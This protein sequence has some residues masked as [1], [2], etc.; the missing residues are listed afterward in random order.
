MCSEVYMLDEIHRIM[1]IHKL[2]SIWI[3]YIIYMHIKITKNNQFFVFCC[4]N[5]DQFLEIH[6]QILLMYGD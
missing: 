4:W 6:L 2:F 5:R 3:F 1:H